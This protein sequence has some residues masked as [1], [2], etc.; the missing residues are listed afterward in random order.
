M[1]AAT[2]SSALRVSAGESLSIWNLKYLNQF[3]GGSFLSL[4]LFFVVFGVIMEVESGD[5]TAP[6][7]SSLLRILTSYESCVDRRSSGVEPPAFFAFTC[8][9]ALMVLLSLR[10]RSMHC[11]VKTE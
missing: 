8:I 10:S 3:F 11:R 4:G 6:A 7:D 9:V 2:T 5:P 1:S